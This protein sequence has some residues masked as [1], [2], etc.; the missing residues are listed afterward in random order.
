MKRREFLKKSLF[1]MAGGMVFPSIV[2]STVFGK[3]NMT[4]GNRIQIASI[5]MG[6]M[7]MMNLGA[8]LYSDDCRVVA[9]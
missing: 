7:G 3:T 8:F 6:A 2:P 1:G 9:V 5:G 4:P